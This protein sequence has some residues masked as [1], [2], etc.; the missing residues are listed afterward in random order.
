MMNQGHYLTTGL[1]LARYFRLVCW[2]LI[3][4]PA[5]TEVFNET[6]I[7]AV[8]NTC[9]PVQYNRAISVYID[10]TQSE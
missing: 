10:R 6:S 7:A 4:Y 9:T 5:H 8:P 3:L 1:L 2:G